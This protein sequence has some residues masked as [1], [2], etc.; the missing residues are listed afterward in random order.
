[1]QKQF[2]QREE[3]NKAFEIESNESFDNIEPYKAELEYLMILEE[4]EEYR[5]AA[6]NGDK[7]QVLDAIADI[8]YLW[9][10]MIKK[11]GLKQKHVELLL[12]EVHKSNMTKLHDGKV[13]KNAAGKV[14]K[15]ETFTPPDIKRILH[16]IDQDELIDKIGL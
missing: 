8:G 16:I 5:E 15:P 9:F 13:V 1:M 11:H 14:I 12:D 10:G 3:F 7:T 6:K 4:I 2:K